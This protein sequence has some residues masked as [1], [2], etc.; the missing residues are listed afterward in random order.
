MDS[1]GNGIEL[2][3]MEKNHLQN[4]LYYLYKNRDRYWIN[5][6]D[7]SMINL[8]QNGDDFFQI[9]IRKS[10][11]WVAITELLEEPEKGFNFDFR[12]PTRY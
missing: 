5:C 9:V 4:V 3:D 12:L 2:R 10:T 7:S 8:F 1:Y 11:L 6:Q